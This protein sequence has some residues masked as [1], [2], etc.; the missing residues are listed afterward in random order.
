MK[1]YKDLEPGDTFMAVIGS[2]PV[3]VTVLQGITALSH[4]RV[5]V[6]VHNPLVGW[7]IKEA[8][9]RLKHYNIED[10]A[11]RMF[12]TA[13][14]ISSSAYYRSANHY[15]NNPDEAEEFTKLFIGNMVV[16][17]ISPLNQ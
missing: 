11:M 14:L 13:N 10:S 16:N 8:I 1:D 4:H 3:W 15:I 5:V 12:S 7:P 17:V 6:G 9:I 2:I